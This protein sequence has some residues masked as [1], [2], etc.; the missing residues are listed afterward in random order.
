MPISKDSFDS[1]LHIWLYNR[2]LGKHYKAISRIGAR[3]ISDLAY[4]THKEMDDLGLSKVERANLVVKNTPAREPWKRKESRKALVPP[5][6]VDFTSWNCSCFGF[7]KHS[8][9]AEEN[10][11]SSV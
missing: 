1:P 10:D 6:E 7:P 2:G 4:I 3:R 8:S 11:F 5:T 9:C